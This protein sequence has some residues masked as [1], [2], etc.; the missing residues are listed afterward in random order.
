MDLKLLDDLLP[1]V[2]IVVIYYTN[3]GYLCRVCRPGLE[4]AGLD[5]KFQT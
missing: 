4:F 1:K 3:T 5:L 2:E